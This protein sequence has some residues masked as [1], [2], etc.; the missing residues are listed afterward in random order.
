MPT[1]VLEPT[2]VRVTVPGLPGPPGPPGSAGSQT[3]AV[4]A[5]QDLSGHRVVVVTAAG[6]VYA[7]PGNPAH[8]DAV[9]GLTTGAALAGAEATILT[10]GELTEPSWSWTPGQPLYV[11]AGGMLTHAPPSSG[12]VQIVALAVAPT[13]LVLTQRQTIFQ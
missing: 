6:A 7:E 11:S 3:I 2:I 8:A 12:W 10:S 4:P 1:T 5:A 9:L 13:R